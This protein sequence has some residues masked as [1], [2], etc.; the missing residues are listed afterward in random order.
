MRLSSALVAIQRTKTAARRYP[1][2]SARLFLF[3][4]S[5]RDGQPVEKRLRPVAGLGAVNP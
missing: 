3:F 2:E 1:F 5:I 4:A